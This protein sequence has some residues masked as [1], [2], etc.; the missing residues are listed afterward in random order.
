MLGALLFPL[1]IQSLDDL[2]NTSKLDGAV[3]SAYVCEMDGDPLY[4]RN[5]GQHVTPASNQKLLS[6]AFALFQLG[7]NY[8][9]FT[10]I[11]KLPTRTFVDTTGDPLL[12]YAQ[13]IN[14][15]EQLRLDRSKLVAV[16]EPYSV[17]IP[18]TW[19]HD[20]L[21][22]RY[23]AGV[24]AFTVDRGGWELWLKGGRVVG[25]PSAFG[26]QIYASKG[27]GPLRIVYDPFERRVTV[28]GKWP[29]KD[30]RLETLSIWRPDREAAF[31]LGNGFTRAKDT[32][33][34]APDFV[35]T[36]KPLPEIISA[37]LPPSDNNIAEQ[38]LLLAARREGELGD[39]P[40]TLAR[41]RLKNFLSR[42]VGVDSTDVKPY[43]GSGMSRHNYVTTRAMAKLLRWCNDQPT[44]QLWREALVSPGRGTLANRLKDVLFQG[45]TGTLDMVTAL[46]G[47]VRHKSGADLIVSVILNQYSCT[48]A[49]ARDVADSFVKQV[50]TT[51]LTAMEGK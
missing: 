21:P 20:D 39:K 5:A 13:L 51:D 38:L 9:P 50:A 28:N 7:P 35:I 29:D 16:N 3:V 31:L 10:R 27:D 4:Q 34:S 41:E 44:A 1:A 45:K 23:A 19:E 15:R 25:I 49:E 32:P 48:P 18:D 42:I 2:L 37:C 6:G 22:N 17:G 12:T 40:Y 14:V 47:Y 33:Q 43:D 11:W 36:G 30:Q 24:T 26:N 46:S 8:R